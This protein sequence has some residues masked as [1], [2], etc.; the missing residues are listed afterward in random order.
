MQRRTLLGLGMAGAAVVSLAGVGAAWLHEPALRDGRLLPPGRK[1][2]RA[3]ANAVLDG[4]LPDAIEDRG[5]A[6]DDHLKR[7]DTTLAGLPVQMQDELGTLLAVLDWAPLRLALASL[8]SA[9]DVATISEVERALQSMRTSS[10]M[11]RRQAYGALRDL[12]HA[13]YFSEPSTWVLLH[14]P[15]PGALA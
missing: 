2:F 12:T 11:L 10:S 13:A 3:V 5:A 7:M 8:S 9:W 6:L 1:V 14:Y 4:S 15:G